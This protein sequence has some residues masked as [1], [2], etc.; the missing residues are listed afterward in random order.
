MVDETS[1]SD[2]DLGKG[3]VA[4][5]PPHHTQPRHNL[6]EGTRHFSLR[7]VLKTNVEECIRLV[8]SSPSTSNNPL[9]DGSD[10]LAA[11]LQSRH[12]SLT[13]ST[14]T[15]HRLVVTASQTLSWFTLA[16]NGAELCSMVGGSKGA[17]TEGQKVV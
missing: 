4:R 12:H 13:A 15:V 16:F 2:G 17:Q 9:L 8:T 7:L 5:C 6:A 10:V 14:F 3:I 11:P 1:G